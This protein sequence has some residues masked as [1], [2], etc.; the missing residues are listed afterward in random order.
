MSK[1]KLATLLVIQSPG[2][3]NPELEFPPPAGGDPPKIPTVGTFAKSFDQ[4]LTNKCFLVLLRIRCE[5]R[6]SLEY[7]QLTQVLQRWLP[8]IAP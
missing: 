3:P 1:T 8:E 7:S 4:I 6:G 5:G 2:L